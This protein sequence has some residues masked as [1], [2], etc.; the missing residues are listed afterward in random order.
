MDMA[1][2][3]VLAPTILTIHKADKTKGVEKQRDMSH[4]SVLSSVQAAVQDANLRT[5]HYRCTASAV[6]SLVHSGIAQ[7]DGLATG[8]DMMVGLPIPGDPAV[9]SFANE[10]LIELAT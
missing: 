8:A 4:V 3:S 6:A 9:D 5:R 7:I 1:H 10:V 2:V